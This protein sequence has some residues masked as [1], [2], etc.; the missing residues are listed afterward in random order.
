[1]AYPSNQPEETQDSRMMRLFL[2]ELERRLSPEN[3]KDLTAAE[4]AVIQR[5]FSD[6]SITMASVKRGEFGETAQKVANEYPFPGEE[7]V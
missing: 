6:N 5:L 3:A 1:M 2:Q 7:E 4:L